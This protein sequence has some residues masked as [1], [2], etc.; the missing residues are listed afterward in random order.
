M[1]SFLDGDNGDEFLRLSG[2]CPQGQR[3]QGEPF[4]GG[5]E[6]GTFDGATSPFPAAAPSP[7]AP[8][9]PS[10]PFPP[11]DVG[12]GNL[13]NFDI[14]DFD[15]SDG[16]LFEGEVEDNGEQDDN[17]GIVPIGERW[18]DEGGEQVEEL[19]DADCTA[20]PRY[21]N[22]PA[23]NQLRSTEYHALPRRL[24]ATD[25]NTLQY[26]GFGRTQHP[27]VGLYGMPANIAPATNYFPPAQTGW[28]F[29]HIPTPAEL[30]FGIAP[31]TA[32]TGYGTNEPFGASTM[33]TPHQHHQRQPQA[34]PVRYQHRRQ[35][36]ALDTSA[37][38]SPPASYAAQQD[39][40][41]QQPH[42]LQA[43]PPFSSIFAP[44]TGQGFNSTASQMPPPFRPSQ[45]GQT[46][47]RR[48]ST[49]PTSSSD[50][51]GFG[52]SSSLSS[53]TTG[54]GMW[55][56]HLGNTGV[57]GHH[58]QDES[59]P[60]P[61]LRRRAPRSPQ[62]DPAR[63]E[64]LTTILDDFRH[65][66]NT[67]SGPADSAPEFLEPSSRLRRRRQPT[68]T[69]GAI[70]PTS[71]SSSGTNITRRKN[72]QRD[73]GRTTDDRKK[74]TKVTKASLRSPDEE[75]I[76]AR[77]RHASKAVT[78]SLVPGKLHKPTLLCPKLEQQV[79]SS[80]WGDEEIAAARLYFR[81]A[82]QEDRV[83]RHWR[84]IRKQKNW[85]KDVQSVEDYGLSDF[86]PRRTQRSK[87]PQH[88]LLAEIGR[89]VVEWPEPSQQSFLT[90]AIIFAIAHPEMGYTTDDVEWLAESLEWVLPCDFTNDLLDEQGHDE[91][92]KAMED[93]GFWE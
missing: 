53:S 61:R 92:M 31:F 60:P 83:K 68:S 66:P 29:G 3:T 35:E 50:S 65:Q 58:G 69:Q 32:Q 19:D 18:E 5:P 24:T 64:D 67:A 27:A 26:Q 4:A 79:W 54:A 91:I 49:Q 71:S 7:F 62:L 8:F 38:L 86:A 44:P 80:C 76:G 47:M 45:Y 81:G 51:H 77:L 13:D 43:Q 55:R 21:T 22:R 70:R 39:Y 72:T 40:G 78:R 23:A 11:L 42:L 85:A 20:G 6:Y 93:E 52:S 46:G 90:L 28:N 10:A 37:N 36:R 73:A 88:E 48:R 74:P 12:F 59:L 15:L 30:A 14:N 1:V 34:Q 82:V 84:Q 9:A 33:N 75:K 57:S 17:R 25:A 41:M 63:I 89:N 16:M 56:D 2:M 87:E